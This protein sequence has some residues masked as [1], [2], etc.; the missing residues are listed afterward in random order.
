MGIPPEA[1]LAV[2]DG[3]ND[4]PM[5]Q[6]AGLGIGYRAKPRLK[7]VADAVIEHGDLTALLWAQGIPRREW[8]QD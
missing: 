7:A 2:G 8:V 4:A 5:I 3:A 6:A 1:V